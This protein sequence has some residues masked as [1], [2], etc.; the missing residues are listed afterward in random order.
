MAR[1]VLLP[2][3]IVLLFVCAVPP[4]RAGDLTQER[5]CGPDSIKGPLR[6]L[7]PQGFGRAD[8]RCACTHHDHC[9]DSPQAKEACDQRFRAEMMCACERSRCKLMCRAVAH[10]MYLSVKW[11][12]A[13]AKAAAE[14]HH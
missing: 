13:S 14:A 2:F 10:L 3:A 12:G 1:R 11:F 7:I 6:Y 8:F 9:Y 4:V 5:P